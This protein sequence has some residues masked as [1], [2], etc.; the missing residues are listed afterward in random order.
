MTKE[1]MSNS[2]KEL[3][4]AADNV[5]LSIEILKQM[6]GEALMELELSIANLRFEVDDLQRSIE[7]AD[8]RDESAE[9]DP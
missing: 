2:S 7:I 8:E 3:H 1:Q 4:A 6:I 5:D 9:A